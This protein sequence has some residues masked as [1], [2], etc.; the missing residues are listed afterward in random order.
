MTEVLP[1][2]TRHYQNIIVESER[3]N[4][5][6]PRDDDII[7]STSYKAGTTWTQGICGALVFQSPDPPGTLDDLSPWLD[8]LFEP[9]ED[10]IPRME[11][12]TNRRYLKTH[13]PLNA[14]PYHAT[15]KYLYVG[16]D[17]RDVWMSM[18]N[19]W[20]N[21]NPDMIDMWNA[22]DQTGRKLP[23]P[24]YDINA[25]FDEWMARSQFPWENDGYPFW[26]HHY[27]AQTWWDFRHLDNILFVH[28]ADLL[29]DLDGQMRRISAFLDIPV[30]ED[31]WPDLVRSVTFDEMKKNAG[32]RAPGADKGLW[33]DATNFFHKGTNRRWE[34]V[35]RP[36]QIERFEELIYELMDA[37]LARWLTHEDGFVDPRT[38]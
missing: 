8:A 38:I 6:T 21:L 7:I 19:H 18:W 23:H 1:S 32:R 30:N 13:L 22:D 4:A 33:K 3:W 9:T 2:V 25:A 15:T 35:L 24:P 14:I 10:V 17:G 31:I 29:A 26:S 16:R 28:F 34:G 12:L 27:H 36:D 20:N 37:D 11:A 5:F